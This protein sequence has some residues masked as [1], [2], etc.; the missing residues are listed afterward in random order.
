MDFNELF[1]LTGDK[2]ITCESVSDAANQFV[3]A[4]SDGK[5]IEDLS[6][7]APMSFPDE[8]KKEV[9]DSFIAKLKDINTEVY[10]RFI[11]KA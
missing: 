8:N 10:T 4:Y 6:L 11:S 2:I 9:L 3:M 5:S 1:V 7:H